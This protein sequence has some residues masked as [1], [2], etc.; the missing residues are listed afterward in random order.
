[1]DGS[2]QSGGVIE[3]ATE[4]GAPSTGSSRNPNSRQGRKPSPHSQ[5]RVMEQP[6]V[7]SAFVGIDVSKDRLDVRVL[8]SGRAFAVPRT[9]AGL[10]QLAS[11]L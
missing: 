4:L 3:P 8:P 11:E 10:D 7:G 2:P 9:G 6:P 1:M 5:G